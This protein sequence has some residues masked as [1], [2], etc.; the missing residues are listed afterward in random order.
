MNSMNIHLDT[1]IQQLMYKSED[2]ATKIST[3]YLKIPKIIHTNTHL[4]VPSKYVVDYFWQRGE[5]HKIFMVC[6]KLNYDHKL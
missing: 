6:R 5:C 4:H 2:M 1:K 3:P